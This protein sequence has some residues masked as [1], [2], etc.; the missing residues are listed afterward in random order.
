MTA[1]RLGIVGLGAVAQA[2]HL[3]L[4]SKR[5]DLYSIAAICDLSPEVLAAVGDRFGVPA[6]RRFAA[7]EDLLDV[8]GLDAVMVLNR[9]SHS[10]QVLAAFSRDLP[11][12]CEKPLAYT[13][14]EVDTLIEAE[15]D[16]GHPAILLGYMKQ[17]DPAVLAAAEALADVDD[18]R[19]IEASVLHPTGAAQLALARVVGP[20]APLPPSV[21]A[22][23]D[24]EDQ[25]LWAAAVGDADE[26]TWRAYRGALVSSLAHDLSIMRSFG[27]PPATVEWADIWRQTSRHAEIDPGRDRRSF[28]DHPPSINA[29]GS[30]ASGG[31]WSLS[32]HYLP[33]FPAYRETIRVVHGRGTVELVFPSPY[34]L[35]APTELTIT[36]RDGSAER[37][38]VR[39]S[40]IE[41]F[42]TQ[43][44]AFHAMVRSGVP[45]RSD[46]A[47]GRADILDCQRIL[48]TFAG[49]T[50]L[51][52]GGEV[53][54]LV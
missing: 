42:E 19:M 21:A 23:G 37:R 18:I 10:A 35:H 31:R 16:L 2:V 43:L 4:L 6:A 51:P 24:A 7:L 32:W 5:P 25:A 11:V 40:P 29:V 20:S 17:Y 41:A 22:S 45:P 54:K 14:N 33:D 50:G 13:T 12:L 52:V 38:V 9:G 27:A 30:L 36:S 49:R 46:L 44:E 47:A 15:P 26:A 39:R 28:G 3:P 8:G 1:I 34:L 48:A 53:G